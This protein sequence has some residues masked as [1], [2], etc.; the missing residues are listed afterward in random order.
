MSLV[1]DYLE[2]WQPADRSKIN[3]L[4]VEELEQDL[5]MQQKMSRITNILASMRRRG[6]I[7]NVGTDR[8]AIW[9]LS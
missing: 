3:E 5:S 1:R 8:A 2:Q 4:L 9:K 6:E 7:V